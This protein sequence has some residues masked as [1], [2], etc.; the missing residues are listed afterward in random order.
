MV[1]PI[2]AIPLERSISYADEVFP[3]LVSVAQ[4]GYPFAFQPYGRV[5]VVR[6]RFAEHLLANPQ[7][8]HLVMLDLDHAH[9]ADIVARLCQTV[10]ETPE[11]QVV[12][13]LTF[14]RGKPYDPIAFRMDGERVYSV[15]D[16]TPGEVIEVDV[17][18]FGATIIAREVFERIEPPWFRYEY[19]SGNLE[20]FPTEDIY[21][22]RACRSAGVR[23]WV[24]T[25]VVTDHL[26]TGRV[27][28]QVFR[29]F[30]AQFGAEYWEVNNGRSEG[31]AEDSTGA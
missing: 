29:A 31:T 8:S 27:N 13:A 24:A 28:E 1:R 9:P 3:W 11:R 5:D 22:S 16:W 30:M 26:H 20:A 14:R 10:E 23:L 17:V 21:F 2:V 4:Q 25:G 7:F 12:S 19:Q 15:V 18:G 6:N